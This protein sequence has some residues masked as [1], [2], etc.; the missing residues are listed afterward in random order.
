MRAPKAIATRSDQPQGCEYQ[1]WQISRNRKWLRNGWEGVGSCWT[2]KRAMHNDWGAENLL[3][4]VVSAIHPA[5]YHKGM[6]NPLTGFS[7]A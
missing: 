2:V 7:L 3:L 5:N 4:V 6:A 1:Q